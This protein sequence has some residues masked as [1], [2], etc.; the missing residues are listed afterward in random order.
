VY[1]YRYINLTKLF[2]SADA[3]FDQAVHVACGVHLIKYE[4][5]LHRTATVRQGGGALLSNALLKRPVE[6]TS[7]FIL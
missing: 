5:A 7:G 2:R 6:N 3:L 1:I 4:N